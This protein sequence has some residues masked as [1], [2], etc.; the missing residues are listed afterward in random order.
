MLDDLLEWVLGVILEGASEAA[1]SQRFPMPVRVLLAGIL[2][3]FYF[4]IAGLLFGVGIV[5]EST[6]LVILGTTFSSALRFMRPQNRHR[7]NIAEHSPPASPFK[8]IREP[9]RCSAAALL[10]F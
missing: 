3:V 2:L 5:S 10:P 6:G 9:P 1:G 7:S 4:G 8:T